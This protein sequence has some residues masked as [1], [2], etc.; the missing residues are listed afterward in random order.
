MTFGISWDGGCLRP[1][2]RLRRGL[3]GGKGLAGGSHSEPQRQPGNV[4][5][6]AGFSDVWIKCYCWAVEH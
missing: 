3:S 4:G 1:A 2:C 6:A 5:A